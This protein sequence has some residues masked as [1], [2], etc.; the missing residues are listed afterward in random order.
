MIIAAQEA[1]LAHLRQ[2]DEETKELEALHSYV[3][4][5]SARLSSDYPEVTKFLSKYPNPTAEDVL[6]EYPDKDEREAFFK[7]AF[8]HDDLRIEMSNRILS[9]DAMLKYLSDEEIE[10]L[11][12]GISRNKMSESATTVPR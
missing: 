6:Q 11:Y 2:E 12:G 4:E 9:S 3:L 10:I 7:Q 1:E 5:T 8:A